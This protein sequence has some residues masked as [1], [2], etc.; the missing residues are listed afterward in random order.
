MCSEPY[1]GAQAD[2]DYST[3]FLDPEFQARYPGITLPP[4]SFVASGARILSFESGRS[5]KLVFP[6]REHQAN[7]IGTLQGGILC[8]FF[9]EAFGILSFASLRKP[10]V[11]I[12]MNVNFIRP[13]RP[14]EGLIIHAEFKSKSKKLL[15]LSAEARNGKEKLAATAFSNLMVYE[16]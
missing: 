3:F 11:S 10:C 12:D 15:Q 4:P 6:V 13:I 14:G 2:A 16:P 7:P 5:I 9:D 1:E 8:S